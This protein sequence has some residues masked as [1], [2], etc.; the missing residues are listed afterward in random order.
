MG[1]APQAGERLSE[2]ADARVEESAEANELHTKLT[3]KEQESEAVKQQAKAEARS[4]DDV[5]ASGTRL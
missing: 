4:L 1:C 3:E 2:I 5:E